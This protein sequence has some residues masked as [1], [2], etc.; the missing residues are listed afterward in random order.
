[1]REGFIITKI[2]EKEV[3]TVEDVTAILENKT[4]GVLI[5]GVYED[6]PGE[7]YYAIGL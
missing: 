6:I 7:Y 2:D 5:E 1:M 4:G 3:S